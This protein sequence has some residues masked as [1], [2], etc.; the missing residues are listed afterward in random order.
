MPL[1]VRAFGVHN[2]HPHSVQQVNVAGQRDQILDIQAV[3]HFIVIGVGNADLDF[4][5]LQDFLADSV[6]HDN[7]VA[8]AVLGSHRAA[9]NDQHIVALLGIDAYV[10]VYVGQELQPVVVDRAQKFADAAR[11]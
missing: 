6:P 2:L 7:N 4:A 8:F 3:D 9:R 5:L 1:N 11:A 10:D